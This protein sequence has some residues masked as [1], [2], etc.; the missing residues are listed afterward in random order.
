MSAY[1][2][3]TQRS[4]CCEAPSGKATGR[5]RGRPSRQ[6]PPRL[7]KIVSNP[8]PDAAL[9]IEEVFLILYRHMKRESEAGSTPEML[10]AAD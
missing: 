1:L 4:D 2:Y 3:D 8:A 7:V 9:R 5:K 6:I 10:D